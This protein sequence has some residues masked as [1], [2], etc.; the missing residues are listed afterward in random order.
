MNMISFYAADGATCPRKPDGFSFRRLPS[1]SVCPPAPTAS[2]RMMLLA[3]HVSTPPL[4]SACGVTK[5]ALGVK[6]A[7]RPNNGRSTEGAYLGFGVRCARVWPSNLCGVSACGRA[8]ELRP[9]AGGHAKFTAHRTM[10]RR[11]FS[12]SIHQIAAAATKPL[13]WPAVLGTV[14]L[15]ALCACASLCFV[16][17]ATSKAEYRN[18]I[19][20]NIERE[21]RYCEIAAR[22]MQQEVLAL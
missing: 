15:S 10:A 9:L 21:E 13:V 18:T 5:D 3:A 8:Q 11:C 6:V 19:K 1:N 4:R 12:P 16:F 22:R 7:C 17:H 20:Q 2:P 14:R